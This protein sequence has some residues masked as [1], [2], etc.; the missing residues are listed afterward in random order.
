MLKPNKQQ[1][2]AILETDRP[3]LVLAGAGS[4]K[5]SVITQKIAHLLKAKKMAPQSIFAVTFTNKAAR[6]MKQRVARVAAGQAGQLNVST[7]HT[8]GLN[9]IRREYKALELKRNFSLFDS[10]DNASLIR[11]LLLEQSSEQKDSKDV[12]KQIQSQIS[13][14]KNALLSPEQALASAAHEGEHRSARVYAEYR[15]HLRAYNALDFDDLIALPTQLFSDHP[16]I[17]DNW[18]DRIRYLMV[19]EYQDTNASQ[20]QLVRQL[21]GVRQAFTVVGDD[22]QS[23]Y[24]WRGAV[25]EN[26]ANLQ[27]DYPRLRVVKLEQN[28][29]SMGRILRSANKLIS[30]NTHL[31]DKK[32]WS[33]MGEGDP[34]RVLQCDDENAEA[35][36]IAADISNLRVKSGGQFKDYAVVYRGNHQARLLELQL[37]KFQVPYK[38]SGGSSFFDK[39]E[40]KDIIAYLRLLANPDDD[41]AYLR[42]INTPRR[43]IG[44]AT[45]E[46]LGKYA[47]QRGAS[48]FAASGEIGLAQ[49]LKP[50]QLDKLLRFRNWLLSVSRRC[51]QNSISSALNDMIDELDYHEWLVRNSSSR[52]VGDYRMD[53]VRFLM[54]SIDRDLEKAASKGGDDAEEPLADILSRILLQDLMDRQQEE[55][56]E[57]QVQL[58]TLHAAKGLEFPHVFI[59][60]LEEGL[61][62]H[63]NSIEAEAIEEER[64]LFYV[65]ITRAQRTLTMTLAAERTQYGDKTPCEPSRF[66]G[67]LPADDLAWEGKVGDKA[68]PAAQ[69][70]RGKSA[71]SDL[72][73]LLGP[74]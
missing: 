1:Q 19:D 22:D 61:L 7:F 10:H 41:K 6:E 31:F 57:N 62:P 26:L 30:Q 39:P 4:G 52:Q 21:V 15:R 58:M 64:R 63:R 55:D 72:K 3:L 12:A 32:L 36:R 50:Q 24:S 67:E 28:Y 47:T 25:P 9:I 18:Q 37:Q 29:R 23:I 49:T 11:D 71:L 66:L 53:N 45:L 42:T 70:A 46:A 73:S 65:G 54:A 13:N 56:D 20:Y 43:Q 27:Q 8:L 38:V 59:M 17:L 40:I 14:W 48:L 34:I 44:P 35:E 51:H 68:D 74:G 60:G 33:K 5:T 2:H 16:Q 69:R